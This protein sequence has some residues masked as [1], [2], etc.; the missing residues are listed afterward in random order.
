M[1]G[2]ALVTGGQQGIGLGISRALIA[3]GYKVALASRSA[4]DKLAV[5]QALAELGPNAIYVQHDVSDIDH[6]PAMLDQVEA[7]L[8]P[9]TAFVNNAGVGAPVRGD[10]LELK[11]EN[12]DFVQ[13]INLRG[14]FFLAQDVA[15]RMLAQPQDLYRSI[16]FVTSVSATMVSIERAEYCVSKA[17]AAMMAQLF[18]VRMAPH[19]IGVFELRPGIIATEMTAG[20]RDKYTDRIEGG[21]VPAA[22]WGEPQDIGSV[23]MPIVEGQMQFATGAAIPVDGGLSITRL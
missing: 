1:T 21:L 3:G 11:P 16:T 6:V 12:W 7:D 5:Q 8:G 22:R 4:P 14:A 9:I 17:A 2:I 18:A 13:N 20:V 23:I 10:M 19:G 15:R